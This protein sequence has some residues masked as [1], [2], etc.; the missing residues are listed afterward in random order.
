MI[1]TRSIPRPGELWLSAPPYTLIARIVR[2]EGADPSL[3]SYEL[4]DDDG[5]PIESVERAVLDEAWWRAFQ[6]LRR[7]YG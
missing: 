6:P 5:H 1:D 3:V 4:C 7:H 2:L